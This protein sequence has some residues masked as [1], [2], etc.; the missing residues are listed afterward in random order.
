MKPEIQVFYQLLYFSISGTLLCLSFIAF[1]G[2]QPTPADQEENIL[3]CGTMTN[4][5][6]SP[7]LEEGKKLFIYNCASCHAKDMKTKLTGPAL[8]GTLD[9]WSEYPRTDLYAWIRNSQAL[10]SAKHPRALNLWKEWQPIV[11]NNNLDL[12]DEEIESILEYISL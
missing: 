8:S 12:T 6:L 11:M 3:I 10:I 9:R 2:L 7:A 1:I 5:R 4:S